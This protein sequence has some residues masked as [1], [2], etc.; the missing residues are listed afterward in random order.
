MTLGLSLETFTIMH[1]VI[2]LIGILS[3]FAV[4]FGLLGA[5]GLTRATFKIQLP[6]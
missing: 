6:L 5:H 2:S 1:V 3:G 4:V